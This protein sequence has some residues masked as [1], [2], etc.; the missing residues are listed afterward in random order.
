MRFAEMNVWVKPNEDFAIHSRMIWSFGVNYLHTFALP[1]ME[2]SATAT[3]DFLARSINKKD[4]LAPIPIYPSIYKK[5]YARTRI[6]SQK[7]SFGSII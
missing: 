5:R 2:A 3:G 4:M 7:K 1:C 6:L